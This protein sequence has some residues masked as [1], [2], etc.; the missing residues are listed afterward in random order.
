M[1]NFQTK[2]MKGAIEFVDKYSSFND[3]PN[4]ILIEG[5]EGSGKHYLIK[6]IAKKF[7]VEP[8][9]IT[10]NIDKDF[11]IDFQQYPIAS[12]FI[13]N[14]YE[15]SISKQNALLKIL[16]EP[17][18]THHFI[19]LSLDSK[20]TGVL[21]TIKNRCLNYTI[22]NFIKE[23]LE[24]F[25][26]NDLPDNWKDLIVNVS[27]TPG[28]VIKFLKEPREKLLSTVELATKMIDKIKIANFPNVLKISDKI[29]YKNEKDKID[30]EFLIR[31]YHY[32]LLES[33]NKIPFREYYKLQVAL[34]EYL[35]K[36]YYPNI[37]KKHLF[38]NFLTNVWII[39]HES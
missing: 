19:L 36:S 2:N 13:I 12:L 22:G 7:N 25:L 18:K 1:D 15:L 24:H 10:S 4:P 14:V 28:D 23:D 30:L 32:Y 27:S 3:F 8:I 34:G 9:D 5:L 29:A 33:Y 16:E 39:E 11:I 37:N 20:R 6:Y 31:I 26:P 35:G 17:P 38:E 21:D